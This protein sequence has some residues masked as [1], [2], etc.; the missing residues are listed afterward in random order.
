MWYRCEAMGQSNQVDKLKLLQE[1]ELMQ[2]CEFCAGVS[3]YFSPGARIKIPGAPKFEAEG[4]TEARSAEKGRVGEGVTPSHGWGS[5]ENENE[6]LKNSD[7][8]KT[9]FNKCSKFQNDLIN[10]L[11]DMTC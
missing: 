10:I 4:F 6:F 1:I 2:N 3:N 9:I 8:L 5:G 7:D 11:G